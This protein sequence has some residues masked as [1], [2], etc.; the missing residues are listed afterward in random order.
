MVALGHDT[1]NSYWT[2]SQYPTVENNNILGFCK[3]LL[4]AY[5]IKQQILT[6]A[7]EKNR[8]IQFHVPEQLNVQTL[9]PCI[10][11][12]ENSD[13]K[14]RICCMQHGGIA[15]SSYSTKVSIIYTYSTEHK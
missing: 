8:I 13:I 3:I 7:I 2:D 9:K 11:T 5:D 15:R 14:T 10:Y 4:N 6:I 1:Y 12:G